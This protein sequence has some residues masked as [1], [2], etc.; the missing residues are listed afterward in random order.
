MHL[1]ATARLLPLALALAL[2]SCATAPHAGADASVATAQPTRSETARLNA[3]FDEKYEEALHFSPIQMTFLG[4]KD[5]N[6]QLDDFSEAGA[7]RQLAWLQAATAEMEAGFDYDALEPEA[8]LSYDLWKRQYELERDGRAFRDNGY[9]FNQMQGLQSQL[10]TLL[11]AFHQVDTEADYLAYL[12]RVAELPRVM[13]QLLARAGEN[14]AAGYRMPRFAYEG[15]LAEARKVVSG[16]PFDAGED[17]ALWADLQVEA[18]KLA[19]AGTID[20]AR[21]AALKAQARDALL[22]HVAPAYGDLIAWA[23]ADMP[24]ARENPPGVG[25]TQPDGEAYYRHQLRVHT[26]TEL[27]ADQIHDIGLREVDRIHAEMGALKDRVGFE[28]T[29]P[30]FFDHIATDPRFKFPDTDA[31]RQAYIDAATR[32]IDNIKAALPD[33]F[34]ILPKA[35]LVVKR[36]EAFREQDGAAQHYYPG[37]PDGARPGVYYAH[38]SAMDAMPI[39]E[40]EVIAYHEGLPG[41][42]MQISIAQELTDV[43][44]FRTQ[45]NST[46]YSE[47]WGLYSEWLAR[48]MPGTYQDPYSE[49][50]RLSSE[51]WRAVRLVVDTGMH[52]K[53]WTEQDAIAYFART[54]AFPKATVRAEV[55]RYITWPGQATAYKIGMLE[56]QGMRRKAEA[57][58][59]DRFDIRGF[60]DA[61]LGGGALPMPL[62]QR[63]VDQWVADTKAG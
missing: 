59:G 20:A 7:D 45:A 32:A 46:A 29:L 42:H 4:R 40:L 50:G 55:R 19:T 48:E 30:E 36:V 17:S 60:H 23:E 12:S 5:L 24:N 38:L 27:T 58:L 6:D 8:R 16:A 57:E 49:Y 25:T 54:T 31:G 41:H 28:G 3:W 2:A 47:G 63:R 33:Y 61:V 26:S 43:P 1:R 13:D 62:L 9:V 10:P 34:G 21:A 52:A 39:P 44:Q 37:T 11:I 35:D 56:I 51:L 14:A 22:A 15:V 53:G 18:D